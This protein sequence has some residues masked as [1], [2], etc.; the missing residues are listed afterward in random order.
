M[1]T[2]AERKIIRPFQES[3]LSPCIFASHPLGPCSSDGPVSYLDEIFRASTVEHPLPL[4]FLEA[5]SRFPLQ[6][7]THTQFRK[8]RNLPP[9]LHSLKLAK[10]SSLRLLSRKLEMSSTLFDGHVFDMD[11]GSC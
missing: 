4:H 9:P 8:N 6:T 5:F 2:P 7:I 11:A 10:N 1:Q 3:L